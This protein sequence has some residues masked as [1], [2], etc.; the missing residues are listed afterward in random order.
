[1]QID[2]GRPDIDN[3]GRRFYKRVSRMPF[4]DDQNEDR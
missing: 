3:R 4:H 2:T 1:M